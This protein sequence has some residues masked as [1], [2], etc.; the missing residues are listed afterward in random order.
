MN[1]GFTVKTVVAI[2]IGVAL[3]VVVGRFA[4]VPTGI[5]NTEFSLGYPI[6]ILIAVLFGPV[7]GGLTGL[8][9]HALKDAIF[10]GSPWWSWVIG[11]AI[12]GILFGIIGNKLKISEGIF[13]LK[14]IVFFNITQIVANLIVWG[15]LAPLGD[16]LI[17]SE[18]Q[19]KVFTQGVVAAIVDS[20]GIGI[21][22][23]IVF[24]IYAKQ[25]VKKGSLKIDE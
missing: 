1:K 14:D 16:I 22:C 7:A 4:S 19:N 17:Y 20:V 11:S 8:I 15:V 18:P 2:A 3:F 6:L 25:I 5:P 23:T 12:I 9:G 21:T 13:K 24:A 10:Y